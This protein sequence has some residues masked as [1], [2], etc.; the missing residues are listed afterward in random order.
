MLKTPKVLSSYHE[1]HPP[2]FKLSNGRLLL[3]KKEVY[4]PDYDVNMDS[5]GKPLGQGGETLLF[6]SSSL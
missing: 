2:Q 1:P 3:T 5:I 6:I 4:L